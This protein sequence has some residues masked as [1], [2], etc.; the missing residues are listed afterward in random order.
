MYGNASYVPDASHRVEIL[1][2]GAPEG[3][4][5]IAAAASD[6]AAKFLAHPSINPTRSP[7]WAMDVTHVWPNTHIDTG[8]GGFWTH[9]FWP[10][11]RNKTRHEVRFYAPNARTA[12][13][14]FQQ[15]SYVSRVIE[16]LLEDLSNVA[17]VQRGIESRGKDFMQLQDNEVLIRHQSEQVA[18]WVKA[19][20]LRDALTP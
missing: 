8:P 10:L 11:S 17:R 14:R 9:Q 2:Y 3:G 20:T 4:S 16:V 19:P 18:K 5:V 15:E 6:A 1:A 13:E 7:H 12:R